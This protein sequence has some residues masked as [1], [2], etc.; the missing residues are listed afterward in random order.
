MTEQFALRSIASEEDP[1]FAWRCLQLHTP[2]HFRVVFLPRI[3]VLSDAV[4]KLE[5]FL[6]T[7]RQK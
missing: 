7:Y 4:N 2:D 5:D 3:E 1:S 6:S